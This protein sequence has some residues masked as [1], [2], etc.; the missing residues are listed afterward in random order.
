MNDAVQ[1]PVDDTAPCIGC[2]LCCN[3]TLYL[4]AKVTPGEEPRLIEHG[5]ELTGDAEKPYF[6]LPCKYESCGRCT[7]YEKRFDICRSFRCALLRSYQAGEID[8]DQA[9]SKVER[10]HE[11]VVAVTA[12]DPSAQLYKVR[13][14]VREQLAREVESGTADTSAAQRLLNIVALDTFLDR[15]FR[16]KKKDQAESVETS[17]S[18]S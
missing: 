15:W 18:N 14:D 2:G 11:L 10:A 1:R 8:G 6:F 17:D 7:I 3:G 12:S 9:R 13:I 4:R 5:L 16:L